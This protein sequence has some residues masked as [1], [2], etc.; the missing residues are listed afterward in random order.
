MVVQSGGRYGSIKLDLFLRTPP[1]MESF[2]L[3]FPAFLNVCHWNVLDLKTFP[4]CQKRSDFL[5]HFKHKTKYLWNQNPVSFYMSR[6]P[7]LSYTRKILLTATPPSPSVIARSAF[8]QHLVPPHDSVQSIPNLNPA[9][10]P[11]VC[12][13]RIDSPMSGPYA[14]DVPVDADT[15]PAPP[16]QLTCAAVPEER[17]RMPVVSFLLHLYSF[18]SFSSF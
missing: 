12:P 1:K 4:W 15:E 7:F 11:K 6:M 2:D 16:T 10:T 5:P 18:L 8:A 13:S 9:T 17:G 14:V 3:G